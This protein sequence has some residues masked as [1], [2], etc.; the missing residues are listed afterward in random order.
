MLT[1]LNITGRAAQFGRGALQDVSD[2]LLA[3]FAARLE[4]D[5]RNGDGGGVDATASPRS[6][7]LSPPTARSS[8]RRDR[9]ISNL[10]TTVL[11]ILLRRYAWPALGSA[12]VLVALWKLLR[13]R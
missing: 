11:P 2:K 3:E 1:D 9:M 10:G 13:R 6:S 5:L 4:A 12:V 8:H 7:L